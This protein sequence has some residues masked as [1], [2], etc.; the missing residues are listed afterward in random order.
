MIAN[1]VL[2]PL[3]DRAILVR[4]GERLSDEANRRAVALAHELNNTPPPGA[5]E[6][7][8][9]LV[10]VLVRYDPLV[11]GFD[12]MA[13]E[14]RML[15]SSAQLHQDVETGK[16]H[17]VETHYG[18][19]HGPDLEEVATQLGMGVEQFVA[20]HA[21]ASLR[22]LATGF[23]PGFVYCGMHEGLPAVSR[24]REVRPRVPA[25]SILFAAGQTAITATE[26]PTG[27]HVIGRT[28]FRNF[29]AAADPATHLEAG[30]KVVFPEAAP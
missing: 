1:P 17:T 29:D 30:D 24:R 25:G 6:I 27:W 23:A 4:F 3:G 9:N 20:H 19:E 12:A 11:M 10:S 8:P 18:A 5:L 28:E 26:I 14:L 22:V 16:Q 15:F 13:A 2:A 7:V 21:S